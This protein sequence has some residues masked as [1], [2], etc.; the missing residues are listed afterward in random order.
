ME[1]D[2]GELGKGEVD[3]PEEEKEEKKSWADIIDEEEEREEINKFKGLDEND[4]ELNEELKEYREELK[5]EKDEKEEKGQVELKY[6]I[7][8]DQKI[9][10]IEP[11]SILNPNYNLTDFIAEFISIKSDKGKYNFRPVKYQSIIHYVYTKLLCRDAEQK[12]MRTLTLTNDIR[13]YFELVLNK[14]QT[15]FDLDYREQYQDIEGSIARKKPALEMVKENGKWVEKKVNV[16]VGVIN[17]VIE[18][19]KVAVEY[20]LYERLRAMKQ[21]ASFKK[22]LLETE[23]YDI[24]YREPLYRSKTNT[25][26]VFEFNKRINNMNIYGK[27][28][29]SLRE[30]MKNDI[31]TENEIEEKTNQFK[32]YV[33]NP[34]IKTYLQNK[35]NMV[36]H[37]L[38][39]FFDY[40]ISIAFPVADRPLYYIKTYEEGEE[41]IVNKIKSD[42]QRELE[43]R[44]DSGTNFFLTPD[45]ANYVIKE[46]ML[47]KVP[48]ITDF[49]FK[50]F[51]GQ[52]MS[53]IDD[54]F[55]HLKKD[56][57]KGKEVRDKYKST[58]YIIASIVWA[59]TYNSFLEVKDADIKQT[60]N[61]IKKKKQDLLESKC[62]S[63]TKRVGKEGCVIEA[64]TYILITIM[65]W[66]E[67]DKI[68][69]R[70]L[71]TTILILN[72]KFY[73]EHVDDFKTLLRTKRDEK[74][75][76]NKMLKSQ[77]E[78]YELLIEDDLLNY[79]AN[80]VDFIMTFVD[81]NPQ[82]IWDSVMFFAHKF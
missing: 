9:Y 32:K 43:L 20:I 46:I 78:K 21:Y 18:K 63:E 79:L 28:L 1:F 75:N 36:L 74:S 40:L 15:H 55:P 39:Y 80:I 6:G 14:C 11:N 27:L 4:E 51:I 41:K 24:L 49:E 61:N 53:A 3:Y 77:L 76:V 52:I 8:Y 48:L 13:I 25:G 22:A 68:S 59:Y 65:D 16:D 38:K 73:K 5:E 35:Y 64:L 19:Y 31:I 42:V 45:M 17:Y 34:V 12:K 58:K 44:Q 29:Q 50:Q 71:R 62:E 81:E 26:F 72:D 10:V 60:V 33:S 30:K 69:Q 57:I 2:F 67:F 7:N 66:N 56:K 82:N 37:L 54:L 70:E 47:S 23:D